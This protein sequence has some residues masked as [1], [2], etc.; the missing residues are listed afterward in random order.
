MY[1]KNNSVELKL[2]SAWLH[3]HLHLLTRNQHIRTENISGIFK[4]LMF[5]P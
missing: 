4:M 1:F 3:V 2:D 5:V